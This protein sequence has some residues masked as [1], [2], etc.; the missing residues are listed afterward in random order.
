MPAYQW[1]L[2]FG[3]S[4]PELQCLAV[5]VLSQTA[6]SSDAERNWSLF[7]FVQNK[8][9]C[10]LKTA[11]MDKLVYIHANTRLLDKINEVDYEEQNVAWQDGSSGDGGDSESESDESASHFD[12]SDNDSDS[13]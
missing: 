10:R 13:S 6:S 1:W 12:Q 4:V 11:T 5:R 9:C 7:G 8:R 3:A 2:N